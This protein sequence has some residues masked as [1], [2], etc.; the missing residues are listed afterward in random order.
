MPN[1]TLPFSCAVVPHREAVHVC[2]QGELDI[3]TVQE[4]DA[5]L[6]ELRL[7]GFDE[8][9]LDLSG[10]TF[11]DSCGVHLIM[12]WTRRASD[13]GFLFSV[14]AGTE[15]VDPVLELTG[16]HARVPLAARS[17]GA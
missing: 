8:I 1:T 2:P 6:A 15:V 4:V 10:L 11:F 7:A 9:V 12:G 13:E 17:R 14:I 5:R 16:V 3:G